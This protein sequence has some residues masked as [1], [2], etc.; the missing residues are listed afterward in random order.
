MERGADARCQADWFLLPICMGATKD[1]IIMINSGSKLFLASYHFHHRRSPPAKT[2]RCHT[3]FVIAL[4][5]HFI[6]KDLLPVP[7]QLF[8]QLAKCKSIRDA[9]THYKSREKTPQ[10]SHQILRFCIAS[11]VILVEWLLACR[12]DENNNLDVCCKL[13]ASSYFLK[14]CADTIIVHECL[15]TLSLFCH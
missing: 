5:E 14:G 7:D 11:A 3:N 15:L 6:M 12:M 4:T 2:K 10:V 13:Y 9:D 8:K 1:K